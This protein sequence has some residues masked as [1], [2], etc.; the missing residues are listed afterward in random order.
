MMYGLGLGASMG[1]I[2]MIAIVGLVVW[3]I[4]SAAIVSAVRPERT[5]APSSTPRALEV[6]ADRYAR[7]EIDGEEYRNTK[8]AIEGSI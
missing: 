3:A 6:L 2:F 1:G 8:A 4:V 7:G 5:A